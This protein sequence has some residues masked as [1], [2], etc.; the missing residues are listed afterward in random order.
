MKEKRRLAERQPADVEIR[1][2]K[3][4]VLVTY[5]RRGHSRPRRGHL[6]RNLGLAFK[7]IDRFAD[8]P[9]FPERA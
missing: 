6:Y 1:F 5:C 9:A 4:G 2:K 8:R 3:D 7:G